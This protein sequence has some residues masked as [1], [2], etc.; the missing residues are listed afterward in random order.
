MK[1]EWVVLLKGGSATTCETLLNAS[2]E[3]AEIQCNGKPRI[4]LYFS[5]IG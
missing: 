4:K 5:S 3:T 2:V 1:R